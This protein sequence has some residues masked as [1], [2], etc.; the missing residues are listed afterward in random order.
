MEEAPLS[1]RLLGAFEV[2]VGGQPIRSMRTRS[3]EWLLAL[4]KAV[5]RMGN[6]PEAASIFQK[7][8]GLNKEDVEAHYDWA[9]ALAKQGLAPEATAECGIVFKLR[10]DDPKYQRCPLPALKRG[11]SACPPK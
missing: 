8:V 11:G 1:I 3:V 5:Y 9:L 4:G 2:R 7:A 6:Y 10:P